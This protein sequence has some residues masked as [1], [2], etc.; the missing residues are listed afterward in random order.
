VKKCLFRSILPLVCFIVSSTAAFA[1]DWEIHPG[2]LASCEYSDN[3]FGVSNFQNP[4]SDTTYNVGP[5]LDFR[6]AS[7]RIVFNFSGYVTKDYHK[8][9]TQDDSEEALVESGLNLTGNTQ[10]MNLNYSYRRTLQRQSLDMTWGEYTYHTGVAEYRKNFS[11]SDSIN[12]RYIY[13]QDLAPEDPVYSVSNDLK[14]NTGEMLLEFSPTQKNE[15]DLSVRVQDY[16]YASYLRDNILTSVADGVWMYGISQDFRS[17]LEAA[18]TVNNPSRDPD[19]LIY[20][21]FLRAEYRLTQYIT[22]FAKAGY[23]C[24]QHDAAGSTGKAAGELKIERL[25]DSDHFILF[26]S[27]D[28]SYDYT[29]GSTYGMYEITAAS[30]SWEHMFIRE[31]SVIV[32]GSLTERKPESRLQNGTTDRFASLTLKY[33]PFE[34]LTVNGTYNNLNTQYT[35]INVEDGNTD[36]KRE[37]RYMI[38][39]EMRY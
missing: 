18:C 26:G 23:T 34:W 21:G 33:M 14:I 5:T 9:N 30:L 19:S 11:D 10:L 1:L 36:T 2:I 8:R 37:N 17:G 28:F 25:T 32:N 38:E 20:E 12:L 16:K 4:Q 15:V 6:I 3:Y 13:E 29:T 24:L 22:I 39:I 31:F 27:K 35:E 7:Q